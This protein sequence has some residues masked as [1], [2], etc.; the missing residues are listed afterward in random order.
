[1]KDLLKN[2]PEELKLEAL[3]CCWKY[4]KN[5]DGDLVKKPFNVLTG[6]GAR[7]NDRTTFVSYPTM[8]RYLDNYISEVDNKIQGGAGL[9][10]FNGFS[11]IDIDHCINNGEISQMAQELINF[12]DSYTELSPSG[13][14]IR[15]IFKSSV[16]FDKN[17][18]YINNSKL[19]LEIY[20]SDNTNKFVSITGNKLSGDTIK[21]LDLT[22]MLDKYM[23]RDTPLYDGSVGQVYN[24]NVTISL[25]DAL[26]KDNRL[27]DLWNASAPGS[28]S[29][30]SELDMSLACKLAFYC[31]GDFNDTMNAFV[32]SPYYASKDD[33][34]KNK[35]NNTSYGNNTIAG[36]ISYVGTH[37]ISKPIQTKIP[38]RVKVEPIMQPK[39]Y[40]MT[41]V[42]NA[43]R[44]ADMFF[45]D[46]HYNFDNEKW[47]LWNGKYWEYDIKDKI[48]D[49]VDILAEKMLEELRKEQNDV[50]RKLIAANITKIQNNAGKKALLEEC[51]HIGDIPVLN[52]DF[53]KDPYLIC[54]NNMVYDLKSGEV[55]PH[56]RS[57]LISQT[58]NCDI[59]LENEPT[60]WLQFLDEIFEGDKEMINY[61]HKVWS[62]CLSG[63][64]RE[65]QMWIFFGDG[66]N[67]KSLALD[68][69]NEL[70][71]SYGITSRPELLVDS[72]NANT[73]QEEIARLNRKRVAFME[74][75][76]DG[77]RLNESLV[78]QATS[79]V[80]KMTGRFLYGNTFEFVMIAKILM[81]SN[82]KPKIKG[83]DKGIWRRIN[84]VPLYKDFTN[85]ADKD[86]R[87]KL[88]TELPQ[89]AGWLCKGFKLYLE[90]GLDKKPQKVLKETKEY[91]EESDLVQLWINENCEIDPKAHENASILFKDFDLWCRDNKEIPMTQTSFGRNM[92]KKFKRLTYSNGKYYVGIKMR[93]KAI[94]NEKKIAYDLTDIKDEDI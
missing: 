83:I 47:M 76:K 18:Y 48:R 27:Y 5:Q 60:R 73:S 68:I 57:F 74:E 17:K 9:G 92:G 41:D 2:I 67:G 55:L 72:K 22:P 13:T 24:N 80:G 78:K 6:Y 56:Q 33:K 88:I 91:K 39:T 52:E 59:D 37:Q 34:H 77:D 66:N 11:A 4:V 38:E 89:I 94:D 81:A 8:C 50:S 26:Q 65:Q 43:H 61:V 1:M 35:W 3:W 16:R 42:G 79:G 31:N 30:E 70:M 82:Y 46:I 51:Q 10:I 69:L 86:L 84:L 25:A 21:M 53:D 54:A 71:G 62:Y 40:A 28:H 90:E 44:F 63:S 49:K 29:N 7:S 87:E 58:I 93:M 75:I 45:N 14:G 20:I 85:V 15:I 36:A 19:G 64:T 12:C 23:I 32:S